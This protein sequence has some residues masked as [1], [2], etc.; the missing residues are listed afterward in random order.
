MC[1]K[2]T[3][4]PCIHKM[5][6]VCGKFVLEKSKQSLLSDT[7]FQFRKSCAIKC[8]MSERRE[9]QILRRGIDM[10]KTMLSIET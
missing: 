1:F 5:G 3:T 4:I 9:K 6:V 2:A 10:S 8:V 7:G